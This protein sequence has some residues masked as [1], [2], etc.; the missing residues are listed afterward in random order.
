MKYVANVQRYFGITKVI[1]FTIDVQLCRLQL[2]T[3]ETFI[4]KHLNTRLTVPMFGLSKKDLG[5]HHF[6]GDL[7][8]GMTSFI[9]IPIRK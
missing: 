7:S 5:G 3:A 6:D 4:G 8:S 1:F 2:K 9:L